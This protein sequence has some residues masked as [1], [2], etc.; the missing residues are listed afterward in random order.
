MSQPMLVAI[1]NRTLPNDNGLIGVH[2]LLGHVDWLSITLLPIVLNVFQQLGG[3]T[4]T[5]NEIKSVSGRRWF[6]NLTKQKDR[7]KCSI[8][9]PKVSIHQFAIWRPPHNG[10]WWVST[11]ITVKLQEVAKMDHG[12]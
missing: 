1:K 11:G 9:L 12:H 7:S 10:R 5:R 2:V 8:C 6:T 4:L 3:Q